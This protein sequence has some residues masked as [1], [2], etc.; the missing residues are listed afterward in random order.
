MHTKHATPN[1]QQE[2]LSVYTVIVQAGKKGLRCPDAD[3]AAQAFHAA[4]AS[5]RPF[6]MVNK[7]NDARVIACTRRNKD[8]VCVKT[9]VTTAIDGGALEQA[10]LAQSDVGHTLHTY[11]KAPAAPPLRRGMPA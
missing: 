4:E 10:Y 3:S 6:V 9:F 7:G 11:P 5:D 8:G 2:A 1:T